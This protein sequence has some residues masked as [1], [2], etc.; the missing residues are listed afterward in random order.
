MYSRNEIINIFKSK[1]AKLDVLYKKQLAIINDNVVISRKKFLTMKSAESDTSKTSK[2]VQ[3]KLQPEMSQ[4]LLALKNYKRQPRLKVHLKKKF[5]K[6]SSEGPD[7]NSLCKYHTIK[8]DQTKAP[9]NC[10]NKVIPLSNYCLKRN[11]T[12]GI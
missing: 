1:I 5:G 6:Y 11:S 4:H 9:S 10:S 7:P 12:L 8:N 2:N 3:E